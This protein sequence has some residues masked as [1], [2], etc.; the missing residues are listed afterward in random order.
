MG[1]CSSK[2]RDSTIENSNG[3]A[4]QAP[5]TK[6]ASATAVVKPGVAGMYIDVLRCV[7]VAVVV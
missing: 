6:K 3:V 4:D 2:V 5:T 7:V 1:T